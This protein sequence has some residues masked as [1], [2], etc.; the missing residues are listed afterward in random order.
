MTRADLIDRLASQHPKLQ[1]KDIEM[2]VRILLDGMAA[3]L[4]QG[5][6]IE[7]RGFGSFA[8]NYRPSR[9]GRNPKTGAPVK[10]PAKYMPH[11]KVGIATRSRV[12]K[13]F[14]LQM[15]KPSVSP[16]ESRGLNKERP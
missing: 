15:K 1:A 10:V 2:A 8:L 16:D 9:L 5:D 3:T 7:I 11:F 13:L 6:R 4:A 12:Q 14:L